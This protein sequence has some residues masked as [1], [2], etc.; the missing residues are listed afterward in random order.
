MT[1]RAAAL[2]AIA[3]AAAG[4]LLYALVAFEVI[5]QPQ[6]PYF[7]TDL[8][9][10]YYY[11]LLE[12]RF[13]LPMRMLQS[14]GHYTADGVGI[15][16]HGVAP[17]LT[18]VVLDPFVTLHIFPTAAFSVWLWAVVGTVFYHL[19]LFQVM[20]KYIDDATARLRWT[21][22]VGVAIWLCSPGLFLSANPVLYHEA[23]G[24]AYAAMSIAVYLMLRCAVF[25]MPV[26]YVLIPLAILAGVLIHSRPHLA[27]G[28]YVG[29]VLLLAQAYLREA[30]RVLVPG[31]ISLAIL[32]VMALSYLQLNTLRFGSATA[33]HG[34]LEEAGGTE[35]VQF[36]PVFF[37]TD[38]ATAGRGV[39]F[40]EHG[41]FHP[42][43][44]LPNLAVYT[45]DHPA[46][47][48]EIARAHLAATEDRSGWG[49]IEAPHFGMILIWPF[50]LIT[51]IVGLMMARPRIAVGSAAL[52]LLATTGIA[53]VLM[54]SYPTLAFRYRFEL[55]PL[56]IVICL[57]TFPGLMRRYQGQILNNRRVLGLSVIALLLG[58]ALSGRAVVPYFQ[59][60]QATPGRAYAPWDI[61]QCKA[62]IAHRAY[63]ADVED[64]LCID[65][66]SVFASRDRG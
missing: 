63:T 43:R 44:I 12:G 5:A 66:N 31:L 8:Y 27:V 6:H 17:L 54:L 47:S 9:N 45:F 58:V 2:C 10:A 14:E 61:D 40:I 59:S 52:P 7:G 33:Y 20:A 57:L 62:M 29:T 21:L 15:M 41:R 65:P 37:G 42:W 13:D 36:G 19:S 60:Y 30:E 64:A 50:W 51:V 24:I 55:W 11:R 49:M 1:Q 23:I 35:T 32:G 26:R 25:G 4:A 34:G 46:V 22:I 38:Y 28:L 3:L 39:A 53:A 16:Y 18:R 56:I 48:D